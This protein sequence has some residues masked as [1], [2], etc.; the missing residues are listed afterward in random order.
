[1]MELLKD[2][3]GFKQS[4]FRNLLSGFVVSLIALPLA[5]GL[6]IAS[7]VPPM[8]GIISVV[9][10]GIIAALL[11]GS[12]VTIAGPG[13]GLVV[14][15][16]T[17]VVALGD[18]NL[19]VGYTYTLAAIVV[20]GALITI[21]GILRLGNLSDF[22][23]SATIQGMLSAIGLIIIAK[24]IHVMLGESGVEAANN[25]MLLAETPSSIWAVFHSAEVPWVAIIGIMSLGIMAFY[26]KINN[27]TFQAIPA[28]MWIILITVGFYYYFQFFSITSFP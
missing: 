15:V 3:K 6:A 22:F 26:S 2:I 17:S 7:G 12:H 9:I 27:S 19:L 14:V 20:S 5:L 18:G 11:G 23:P 13:N 10:G 8:A 4:G 25:L 21:L 16:L 24:Q 28:P 1:M